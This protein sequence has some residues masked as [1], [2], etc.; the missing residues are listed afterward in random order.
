MVASSRQGLFRSQT[1]PSPSAL[2]AS[3][4]P[5]LLPETQSANG[6]ESPATS[7]TPG[8]STSIGVASS[9]LSLSSKPQSQDSTSSPLSGRSRSK[10]NADAGPLPLGHVRGGGGGGPLGERIFP[11]RSVLHFSRPKGFEGGSTSS[12]SAG[13]SE[14]DSTQGLSGTGTPQTSGGSLPFSNMSRNNLREGA[15]L[16]AMSGSNYADTRS[17]YDDATTTK[18]EDQGQSTRSGKS[19]DFPMTVRFKHEVAEDGENLVLTGWQGTLQKCEEE[20]RL[21]KYCECLC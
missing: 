16:Q 18:P 20:V 8:S 14:F 6:E 15:S 10:T 2:A 11:L 19:I 1:S 7:P 3:A 4:N 9:S 13:T 5:P 12:L 21:D 17:D